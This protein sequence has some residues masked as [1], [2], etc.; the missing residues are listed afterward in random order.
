MKVTRKENNQGLTYFLSDENKCLKIENHSNG[1]VWQF[2][3]KDT[4]DKQDS[5]D[6]VYETMLITKENYQIFELF[7]KLLSDIKTG[8][9]I[10]PEEIIPEPTFDDEFDVR[11]VYNVDPY[12][13]T[14]EDIE[15]L[16]NHYKNEV[17][18]TKNAEIVAS[19]DYEQLY[20]DGIVTW[21]T[22]RDI[23]CISETE[24]G[25]LLEF[26][27]CDQELEGTLKNLLG[28]LSLTFEKSNRLSTPFTR[29]FTELSEYIPEYHQ[30]HLEELAYKK[31]KK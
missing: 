9:I 10:K 27:R 12:S 5:T 18:A 20:E 28:I 21:I 16:T 22:G 7:R 29:M 14:E 19:P 23:A 24:E 3:N 1:V 15:S 4:Y 31:T 30:I 8:S 26:I 11:D 25:I 17:A 2:F 13:L 6:E